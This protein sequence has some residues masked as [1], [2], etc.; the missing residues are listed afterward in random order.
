MPFTDTG[1]THSKHMEAMPSKAMGRRRQNLRC[2]IFRGRCGRDYEYLYKEYR[3]KEGANEGKWMT[4]EILQPTS[5]RFEQLSHRTTCLDGGFLKE[6]G[7]KGCAGMKRGE[8]I[9]Y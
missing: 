9:Y 7:L 6:C 5:Y 8:V 2:D 1:A 4:G 3:M